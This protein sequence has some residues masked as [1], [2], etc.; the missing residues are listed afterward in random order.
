VTVSSHAVSVSP[1]PWNPNPSK[2][3]PCGVPAG[4]TPA[5]QVVMTLVQGQPFTIQ[6]HVVVGDG[7]GPVAMNIDPTGLQQFSNGATTVPLSG[8]TPTN[9]GYYTFNATAP[10]I[11]CTGGPTNDMCTMQIFATQTQWF[12]C[13]TVKILQAGTVTTPAATLPFT[14]QVASGLSFCTWM[15]GQNVI[16]PPGQ[17]SA[18]TLD[19]TVEA[20]YQQNLANPM[21]FSTPNNPNCPGWYKKFLCG[22]SFQPCV[23]TT[24]PYSACNQACI[25]TNNYCGLTE[26]HQPLYNCKNYTNTV[27]DLTGNCNGASSVQI[28]TFVIITAALLSVLV[29]M[30]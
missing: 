27:A 17:L 29:Y 1:I 6:W 12:S 30:F 26:L 11:T 5:D 7:N 2:T 25:N 19:S 8:N 4:T 23:N 24:T 16:V 21:V 15:N 18:E 22:M 13:A 3:S 20:T 9:I 10:T 14:C 28:S